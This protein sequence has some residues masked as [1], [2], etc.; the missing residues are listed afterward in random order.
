MKYLLPILILFIN[1]LVLYSQ[2]PPGQIQGD[3][4]IEAQWYQKDTLIG[5]PNVPE[6]FGVNAYF[7]LYY[8]Y[9][10]FNA[11]IRYEAYLNPLLGYDPRFK[12]QGIASRWVTYKHQDFEFTAGTFYEQFGSGM[13]LRFYEDR[14]LGID[15]ALDGVKV[16]WQ[17][18]NGL[19]I[20]TLVGQQR[21]FF[22]RGEGIIRA[23]DAELLLNELRQ[24]WQEKKLKIQ[25]GTSFVSKYQPDKDPIFVLPENVAA[26]GGRTNISYENIMFLAEYAYKINDPSASN[27]NIYKEGQALY[28]NLSYARK[29]FSAMIA[30]KRLDNMDFRS[31]RTATGNILQINYLPVIVIPHTYMLTS[32]YPYATKTNG[33]IGLQTLIMFIIPKKTKLG[34]PFGTNITL[35]LAQINDILRLPVNDTTP[36]YQSGTL[37][38]KSPFLKLGDEI[39]YRDISISIERKLNNKFKT[40]FEYIYTLYNKEVI[41]GHQEPDVHAH[42]SVFDLH[43]LLSPKYNFRSEL[44][45]LFTEQDHGNWAM[46]L[47]ELNMLP[48]WSIMF[49]DAWNYG[50]S[51]RKLRIHYYT[52]GLAYTKQSTRVSISYGKEHEG[53]LCVGGVCRYSPAIYGARI[54]IISNF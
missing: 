45:H 26:F 51:D 34:G 14:S 13:L 15:N 43:F 6:K 44:Q 31:D 38:Y 41:E 4:Q 54:S 36:I 17:P 16:K 2:N 39:F 10:N 42:A 1:Y 12:G 11:G 46:L 33:E 3:I 21:F 8:Y 24:K 7:T 28:V 9:K 27:K 48:K 40:Q 32:H 52:L 18:N 47:I 5:A 53:V 25:I 30:A 37:G 20:K 22:N 23:A 35:H 19:I 50:N 49:G 29:G